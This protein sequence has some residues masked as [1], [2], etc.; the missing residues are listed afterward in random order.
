MAMFL[1]SIVLNTFNEIASAF[2]SVESKTNILYI[3]IHF[4]IF[5]F[6]FG[7]YCG[8]VGSHLKNTRFALPN[9]LF[10]WTKKATKFGSENLKIPILQFFKISELCQGKTV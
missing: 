5:F 3:N 9:R 6:G 4:A 10:F 2:L 7:R 1:K 8:K